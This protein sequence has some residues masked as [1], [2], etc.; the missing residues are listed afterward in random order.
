MYY[1]V[2]EVNPQIES[3]ESHKRW[4]KLNNIDGDNELFMTKMWSTKKLACQIKL[5]LEAT[6]EY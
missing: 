6:E 5:S 4:P 2:N 1:I 3:L